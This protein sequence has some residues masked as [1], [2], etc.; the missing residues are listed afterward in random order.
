[1]A[2]TGG[3]S[4]NRIEIGG[5]PADV[6]TPNQPVQTGAVIFLHGHGLKTLAGNVAYSQ[7]FGKQGLRVICPFGGRSWW[8]D[9]ICK[10]FDSELTPEKYVV[11]TILPWIAT[12]WQIPVRQTALFGVSMGGQGA[13]RIAYRH[14]RVLPVVAALSPIVDFHRLIGHGLPLDDMYPDAETAR[15]ETATLQINPLNW[16][17]HQWLSCDPQDKEAREGTVRLTSKLSSSGI[18]FD[19]DLETSHG[20]HS[21]KYFDHMAPKVTSW[22]AESLL[23]ESLRE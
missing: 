5:K 2:G 20:G 6:F 3:G 16:P 22:L 10:E 1:M 7:A 15:Q 23:H 8:L 14:A 17:K 19:G 21:W 9:R 4:W 12:N 11:D 18:P 13:V